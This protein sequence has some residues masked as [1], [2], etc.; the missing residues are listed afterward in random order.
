LRIE[1]EGEEEVAIDAETT[2]DRGVKFP[3]KIKKAAQIT[4]KPEFRR[5]FG[6]VG[7]ADHGSRS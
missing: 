6:D 3:E 2:L 4:M 1:I 5:C 7:D